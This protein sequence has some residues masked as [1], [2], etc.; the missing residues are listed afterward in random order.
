MLQCLLSTALA[1]TYSLLELEGAAKVK[2]RGLDSE[3]E[4][5]Y[6]DVLEKK[7]EEEWHV[8][9]AARRTKQTLRPLRATAVR[10]FELNLHFQRFVR[11][12]EKS[13]GRSCSPLKLFQC[14]GY[15]NHTFKDPTRQ[16]DAQ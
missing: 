5:F 11:E 3:V 9:T 6:D 10:D 15:L 1:E 13:S 7:S 2:C 4:Y 8:V 14:L 16:N 12:V